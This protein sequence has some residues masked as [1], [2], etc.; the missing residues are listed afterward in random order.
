MEDY[1]LITLFLAVFGVLIEMRINL[2]KL[3]QKYEDDHGNKERRNQL[4]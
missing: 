4:Y 2:A 1:A 3:C